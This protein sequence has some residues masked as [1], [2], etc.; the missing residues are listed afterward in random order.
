ME[1]P[2]YPEGRGIGYWQSP[3][4]QLKES[5]S[6]DGGINNLVSEDMPAASLSS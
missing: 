4:T 2:F 1:Y 5:R 6:L 3:G